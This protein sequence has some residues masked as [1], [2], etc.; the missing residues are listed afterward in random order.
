MT[1]LKVSTIRRRRTP[2]SMPPLKLGRL[3]V[4]K[5]CWAAGRKSKALLV[6]VADRQRFAGDDLLEDVRRQGI[7][8]RQLV[9]RVEQF[10]DQMAGEGPIVEPG[11]RD[12]GYRLLRQQ[13][14]QQSSTC[15]LPFSA[16]SPFSTSA[17][18][19]ISLVA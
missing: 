6:D 15:D 17:F 2:R 13:G 14:A 3:L 16:V 12:R 19:L 7:G 11:R 4:A 9:G 1:R 8:A 10:A 5:T 18:G